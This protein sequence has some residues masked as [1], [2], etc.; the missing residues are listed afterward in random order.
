MD[1]SALVTV[2]SEALMAPSYALQGYMKWQPVDERSARAELTSN[3]ITVS[4][5]FHFNEADELVRFDTNDR[6]QDGTP[7][8]KLPWSAYLGDY[9]EARGI[10]YP[11]RVSAA[12][13]EPSG[14]YTYVK[15][16][17]DSVEFNV[18]N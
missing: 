16:T 7:P 12:W 9:R 4:G 5:I 3:G 10:R 15:G 6:W 18:K 17:I 11:T 8:K 2:L 1:E 14:D 13:H